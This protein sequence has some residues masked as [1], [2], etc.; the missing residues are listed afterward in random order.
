M[1][2]HFQRWNT[3]LLINQPKTNIQETVEFKLLKAVDT[4]PVNTQLELEEAKWMLGLTHLEVFNLVFNITK[5]NKLLKTW[6]LGGPRSIEQLIEIIEQGQPNEIELHVQKLQTGESQSKW[7]FINYR[8]LKIVQFKRNWFRKKTKYKDR[9]DM[10]YRTNLTFIEIEYIIDKQHLAAEHKSDLFPSGTYE[11]R[12]I[13]S[14][15]K[16]CY[17]KMLNL[18]P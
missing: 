11:I 10:A 1:S 2:Y 4:F 12:E 14:P 13:K 5:F 7:K 18:I 9:E 15:W 8:I 6:I 3:D 16:L 17:L